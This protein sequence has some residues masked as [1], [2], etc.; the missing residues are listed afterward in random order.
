MTEKRY[1]GWLDTN[2]IAATVLDRGVSGRRDAGLLHGLVHA[3][4]DD[5]SH[6]AVAAINFSAHNT[7]WAVPATRSMDKVPAA[8]TVVVLVAASCIIRRL[9]VR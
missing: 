5:G 9:L 3:L 4:T 6:T 2:D 7:F 1:I 8:L